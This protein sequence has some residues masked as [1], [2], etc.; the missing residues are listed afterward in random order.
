MNANRE[1]LL[2]AVVGIDALPDH[3]QTGQTR[4]TQCLPDRIM[5]NVPMETAFQEAFQMSFEAMEK[6][7]HD[8]VRQNRY[9]ILSVP[10]FERKLRNG[11]RSK[12]G[13]DFGSAKP[14]RTLGDLLLH[15]NRKDSETYLAKALALDPNSPMANAGD[16]YGQ[17]TR[18]QTQPKHW[19]IS[20][21]RSLLTVKL[22]GPLLLC[23][24]A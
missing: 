17:V 2:C 22:F 4:T 19:S 23:V 10:H 16:G 14:R 20:K 12:V 11:C 18:R 21:K 6:E 7:P 1:H 9:N 8:Y 24:S 5:S 13:A 15:S 3:R